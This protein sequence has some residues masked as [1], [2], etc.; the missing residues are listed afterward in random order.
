MGTRIPLTLC[1]SRARPT[2]S[3]TS[4]GCRPASSCRPCRS[5]SYHGSMTSKSFSMPGTNSA[6]QVPTKHRKTVAKHYNL[7]FFTMHQTLKLRRFGCFCYFKG[8]VSRDFWPLVFFRKT[9]PVGPLI[10]G[11][12]QFC[13]LI[14]ICGV[15]R[16]D[17]KRKIDSALCLIARSRNSALCSIARSSNYVWCGIPVERLSRLPTMRHSAESTPCCAAECGVRRKFLTWISH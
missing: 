1:M 7:N 8:T 2:G 5:P 9:V 6:C 10:H 15:I 17:S 11:L 14:R 12:K 13:I 3:S 4:G 16:L